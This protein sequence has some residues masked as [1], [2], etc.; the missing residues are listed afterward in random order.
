MRQIQ[1]LP[2]RSEVQRKPWL[3]VKGWR[4]R[5]IVSHGARGVFFALA[6]VGLGIPAITVVVLGI[7]LVVEGDPAALALLPGAAFFGGLFA[8]ATHSW[9]RW[10]N[11]G[12]SVCHLETLP[13]VIGGWFGASVEVRLP[14][15]ALPAVL[16]RLSNQKSLKSALEWEI[17][18]RVSPARLTRIQGDRYLV[19]VRF[20]IPARK[21]YKKPP[22]WML[23][24][25][26]EVPGVDLNAGFAVP[27]FETNEAPPGEQTPEGVSGRLRLP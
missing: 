14:G 2:T 15:A 23:S 18:E 17:S 19:P 26:A 21:D 7:P 11:F 4:E 10:R 25:R 24:I 8:Y 22:L 20:Q 3:A 16:V 6:L 5:R 12:K 9:L 13:G 1:R 27:V